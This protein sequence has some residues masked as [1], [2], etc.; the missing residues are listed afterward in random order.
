MIARF[1]EDLD[2]DEEQRARVEELAAAHRER[3]QKNRELWAELRAAERD[4]DQARA[5]ELRAQMADGENPWDSIR[6]V[7]DEV[8]PLLNE[9]QYDRFM[10]MRD[11]MDRRHEEGERR[12]EARESYERMVHDLPDQLKLDD[13][14]REA[15][16]KLLET[17]RE[18]SRERMQQMRPL[19]E[20][21]RQAREAGDE[22]RI[23]ELT[24]QVEELQPDREAFRDDFLEQVEGLLN[25]TQ[26]P[27]LAEYRGQFA[28]APGERPLRPADVRD[29]LTAARRVEL[30]REQRH[31]LRL[32]AREALK[33]AYKIRRTDKEAQA[34]LA[35]SVKE[36]IVEM[37]EQGQRKEFERQIQRARST[38]PARR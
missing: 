32:V 34:A 19:W 38:R 20:Q 3:M 1:V 7:L 37:L 25:D 4:G 23:E 27:L 31:R 11:G 16:D 2:L 30:E 17:Q 18:A 29:I 35:A 12:R 15:Y 26:K 36:K 13:A 10:E 24:R 6:Q 28:V 33:D 9:E 8:E 22:E 5:A 14:Q 21:M